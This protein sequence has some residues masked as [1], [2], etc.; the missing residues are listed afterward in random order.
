MPGSRLLSAQL[1]A[2][3]QHES[4]V[5]DKAAVHEMRVAIRRLRAALRVLGLKELDPQ[6]KRLQ[7]ALGKVRDL[8]LQVD[9]LRGRDAALCNARAASLRGAEQGLGRELSRW[10]SEALPALLQ[11]AGDSAAST[12]K[13][14]KILRKRLAMLE[15]RLERARRSLSP[16]ALH[17]ARISV[18]QVR[19]LLDAAKKSLPKKTLSLESDLKTLQTTLGELHDLDVRI[20]LLKRK[21]TLLRDQ[22][23]LRK[24]LGEIA[25]AQ[26]DRWRDQHLVER[27]GNALR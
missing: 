27:A 10:R 14:W 8:Q 13:V 16:Q 12:H 4:A 7:D 6:V 15:E 24:R 22:R 21:P 18:K 25:S 11:A 5:P 23:E 20:E 1:S 2:V 17:R 9:W 19:Y 3:E 26:L